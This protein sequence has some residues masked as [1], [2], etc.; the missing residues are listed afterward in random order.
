MKEM[1]EP[2]LF[3][4]WCAI[5]NIRVDNL[6]TDY[7]SESLKSFLKSNEVKVEKK[8]LD[9]SYISNC[10]LPWY[11]SDN[12]AF[13]GQYKIKDYPKKIELE[14][15]ACV[16]TI[17]DNCKGRKVIVDGCHRAVALYQSNPKIIEGHMIILKTTKADC[18]FSKDIGFQS[19]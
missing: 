19:P 4:L 1:A 12:W 17:I 7:L 14:K 3:E 18:L 16:I 9:I 13:G 15:G 6:I 10:Y 5:K 2:T 11:K 8:P